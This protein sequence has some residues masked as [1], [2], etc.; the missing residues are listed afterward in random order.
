MNEQLSPEEL[1]LIQIARRLGLVG[2][3]LDKTRQ[4]EA[5]ALRRTAEE[6]AA[7]MAYQA[8]QA[9]CKVTEGTGAG[10]IVTIVYPY[11]DGEV[12]AVYPPA[13][14]SRKSH[15][16]TSRKTKKYPDG[17]VDALKEEAGRR[18]IEWYGVQNAIRTSWGKAIY[19]RFTAG[20][21]ESTEST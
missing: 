20:S 9:A 7:T 2:T 4:A 12:T 3:L 17:L 11:G 6:K 8:Y 1:Q 10:V 16:I 19:E 18:G 15:T 21:A 5:A 14:K 13:H